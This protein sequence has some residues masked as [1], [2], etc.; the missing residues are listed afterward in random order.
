VRHFKLFD[1]KLG[2]ESLGK[3]PVLSE[4]VGGV[5]VDWKIA[6]LVKEGAHNHSI[7]HYAVLCIELRQGVLQ[8][9]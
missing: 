9:N 2:D 5:S 6:S 3:H 7:I 4:N 1:I 8:Q